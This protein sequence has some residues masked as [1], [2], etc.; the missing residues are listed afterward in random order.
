VLR[1]DVHNHLAPR[2]IFERLPEGIDLAEG[3]TISIEGRGTARPAPEP[4]LGIEAHRAF[5]AA[6]E[7]D[8]SVIGPWM[9]LVRGPLDAGLQQRWCRVMNEE[10]AASVRGADH[11]FFLA[12]LP[13]LDAG[14][15]AEELAWAVGE[16]AVGGMLAASAGNATLAESSLEPLWTAAER[17]GVPLMIHPGDFK[18]PALLA[19]HGAASLVGN[20][21]ETTLAA[22]SLI[23]TGVPDRFPELRLVLV[24]GGG[25]LPYQ[26]ARISEGLT[27]TQGLSVA[28]RPP[29]D[30]L[31]WFSY[32]TVLFDDRPTR[33]LLD[34]VGPERVLAGSDCP[35]HMND[36]RPYADPSSLSLDRADTE[37]VLGLNAVELFSLP[38]TASHAT[39]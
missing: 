10:L 22:L 6:R 35:F 27:R 25:Y 31:R 34:L 24:H 14:L 28:K 12:A 5:Q 2:Q 11:S 13:D 1:V 29:A 4:L 17:I 33:Y 21:F 18:P 16:G 38:T 23:A 26:F 7:V 32:D 15:A 19:A 37:R 36:H 30:Y 9:E 20:P 8:V 39:S 3:P